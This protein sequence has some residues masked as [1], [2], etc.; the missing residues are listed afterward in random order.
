MPKLREPGSGATS[1]FDAS[2]FQ[3]GTV[4][5]EKPGPSNKAI[6][7]G[8]RA[9]AQNLIDK[10]GFEEAY[11]KARKTL[12]GSQEAWQEYL[13]ANPIFDPSSQSEPKLNSARVGWKQHFGVS[14]QS[15][16]PSAGASS[17]PLIRTKAEFDALPSGA[18]YREEEGG[19]R[20]TKP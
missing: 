8:M 17:T 2:M 6:S 15:Q 3:R 19:Q 1:D 10:A 4:G 18:I 13:E 5:V 16:R 12:V 9:A 20:F 14:G 7:V 11:F